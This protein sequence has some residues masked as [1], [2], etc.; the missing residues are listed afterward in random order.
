MNSQEDHGLKMEKTDKGIQESPQ[1][2]SP[3]LRMVTDKQ[4]SASQRYSEWLRCA[5]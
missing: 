1:A 3:T 4:S 2:V 5:R